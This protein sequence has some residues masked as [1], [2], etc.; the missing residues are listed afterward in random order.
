[1]KIRKF[2]YEDDEGKT[3]TEIPNKADLGR[4]ITII[5][6][7]SYEIVF[8]FIRG[9]KKKLSITLRSPRGIK[10]V[11]NSRGFRTFYIM[12]FQSSLELFETL[13]KLGCIDGTGFSDLRMAI[14]KINKG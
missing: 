6:R 8:N 9:R 7:D 4:I 5:K 14:N 12:E 3:Y 11:A 1:M 2:K 10:R 13:E